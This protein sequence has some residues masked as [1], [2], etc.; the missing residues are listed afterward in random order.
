[1]GIDKQSAEVMS[2]LFLHIWSV[3]VEGEATAV[4]SGHK[5]MASCSTEE[6][7]LSFPH[8]KN[9]SFFPFSLHTEGMLL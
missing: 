7:F 3:F 5:P 2:L 9:C 1:M 8:L 6:L 4:T